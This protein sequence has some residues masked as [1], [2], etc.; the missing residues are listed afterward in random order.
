M[1]YLPKIY[2]FWSGDCR[3]LVELCQDFESRV[4]LLYTRRC[5]C[6][7]IESVMM[8]EGND[9]LSFCEISDRHRW[10]WSN[11]VFKVAIAG[12]LHSPLQV[13]IEDW[14]EVLSQN[15]NHV[16]DHWQV[17]KLQNRQVEWR[18]DSRWRQGEDME[19]G[20]VAGGH[21][22]WIKMERGSCNSTESR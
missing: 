4:F 3:S 12:F 5:V 19:L 6:Q 20:S 9:N 8:H 17:F 1:Y 18:N 22:R 13:D 10:V 11:L 2:D 7:T 14:F 21:W 16:V 15:Q